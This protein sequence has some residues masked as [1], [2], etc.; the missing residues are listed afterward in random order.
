MFQHFL[1]T[2]FNLRKSDWTTNKKNVA[3]LTEEWH[4]N[5]FQLFTDYCFPSVS[6]QTNKNFEWL[7]FF[8]VTTPEIYQDK[9]RILG[10]QL[11]NFKPI[12][13][14]GMEQFL[15]SLK[16]YISE[17]DTEYIITSGLDNDDCLSKDYIQSVQNRFE[18]Q[19]FMA[20]D[21]IDG[22]TLQ[23][24]P[25]YKLGKKLHLYN[26]FISLI[27]KNTNIVTVCNISHR[28]WKKESRITHIKNK[29]V[30]TS[31][32]HQENKV[33]EFDGYGDVDWNDIKSNFLVSESASTAI[34]QNLMPYE[35]WRFEN[36]TNRVYVHYV[37]LS[38]TFKKKLGI[39]KLKRN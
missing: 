17:F 4:K 1:I 16:N 37:R 19:E 9:I 23:I 5:R 11:S 39:Y 8:D 32:I 10:S 21:F 20:I 27:E 3:V 15:P 22:Y 13:A 7:V 33:N 25:T 14:D 26:P 12:F 28:L 35:Q 2:R 31:V 30:W 6:A 24:S 18:N 29:R 34:E 38:K 36:L